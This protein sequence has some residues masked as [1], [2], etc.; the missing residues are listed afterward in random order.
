[1]NKFSKTLL[2]PNLLDVDVAYQDFCNITKKAVKKTSHAGIET[3]I[4]RA[5]MQSV[6]SSIERPTVSSGRQLDL[7]ATALLAKLDRKQRDQWS[8]AV[9]SINFSHSS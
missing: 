4:F 6:N 3:T 9:W 5:G 7:V 1:M 8:K 2:P